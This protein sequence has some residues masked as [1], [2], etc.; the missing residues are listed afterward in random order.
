MDFWHWGA[1]FREQ[2]ILE[3]C[4]PLTFPRKFPALLLV[5]LDDHGIDYHI[6]AWAFSPVNILQAPLIPGISSMKGRLNKSQQPKLSSLINL[7]AL[8]ATVLSNCEMKEE[9]D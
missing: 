7:T 9:G 2:D 5:G 4:P 6:C 1:M 8:M 3:L